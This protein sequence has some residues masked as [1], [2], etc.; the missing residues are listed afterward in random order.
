M[1]K[2]KYEHHTSKSGND[3]DR[4]ILAVELAT[5]K[6]L[7]RE[8]QKQIQ[9]LEQLG[10]NKSERIAELESDIEKLTRGLEKL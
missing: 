4:M 10:H 7:N 9:D 8:Q 1:E 2:E 5:E 3:P 6:K